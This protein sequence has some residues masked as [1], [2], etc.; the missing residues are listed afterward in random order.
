M[1]GVIC[2]RGAVTFDIVTSRNRAFRPS[3]RWCNRNLDPRPWIPDT[4][5]LGFAVGTEAFFAVESSANAPQS[6]IVRF[7]TIPFWFLCVPASALP[8]MW[9]Y[10]RLIRN[11]LRPNHCKS[12]GYNLAGNAS[13]VCPECGTPIPPPTAAALQARLLVLFALALLS[14]AGCTE[15]RDDSDRVSVA[16][17]KAIYDTDALTK[18]CNSFY[19]SHLRWPT[20]LQKLA[21]PP[22]ELA[23]PIDPVRFRWSRFSVQDNGTL[24]VEFV[25]R[26]EQ[27][28]ASFELA[29]PSR[30]DTEPITVW[31]P[32]NH[33]E[34]SCRAALQ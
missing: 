3:G 18:A 23:A 25:S 24:R 22:D 10:R 30:P 4:N 27:R 11:R 14:I 26:D 21:S 20:S 19:R 16:V 15:T 33:K 5:R 6:E 7:V 8:L 31:Q 1:G 34:H 29:R 17:R 32:Y 13:G 9:T 12:C 2:A 28:I